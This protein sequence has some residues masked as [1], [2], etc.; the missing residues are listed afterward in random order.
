MWES[1]SKNSGEYDSVTQESESKNIAESGGVTLA[2]E[3]KNSAE[4]GGV[5]LASENKNIAESGG[6]PLSSENKNIAESGGVP[7][8]SE[9]K[10]IAES[11]GVPLSRGIEGVYLVNDT[12]IAL[13]LEKVDDKI[14]KSVIELKPQKVIT[15]DRLF[16][17]NDQLK[18]N[19]ALQM[20]DAGIEFKVVWEVKPFVPHELPDLINIAEGKKKYYDFE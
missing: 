9:N 13:L 7:L 6:V 1:E 4:H 10:N 5:T 11:G 2:S 16:N 14:I 17:N 8:S 12:E 15:L 3:N 19:T 20:K 18:T